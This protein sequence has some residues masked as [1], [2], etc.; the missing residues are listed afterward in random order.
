MVDAKTK[1]KMMAKQ[2]KDEQARS[3]R[4]PADKLK[5][6]LN[7][8]LAEVKIPSG[9]AADSWEDLIQEFPVNRD[10]VPE[11]GLELRL[12]IRLATSNNRYLITVMECMSLDSRGIGIV[13]T[14][15]N[16]KPNERR[17]QATVEKTYTGEFDDILRAKHTLW[18]QSFKIED[19]TSALCSCA[20]AILSMELTAAPDEP[21]KVESIPWC[22]PQA[23]HVPKP[24]DENM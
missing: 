16:W 15:I 9:T 4:L 21:L 23:M 2:V 14:H 10:E 6:L 1:K 19:F 22:Q 5:E 11:S 18:A 17:K 12:A 13:S 7:N 24:V 8:W 3:R 20:I